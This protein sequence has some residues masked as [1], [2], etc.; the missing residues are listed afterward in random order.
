[1]TEQLIE[2]LLDDMRVAY[3]ESADDRKRL[4]ELVRRSGEQIGD[5]VGE[6][7]VNATAHHDRRAKS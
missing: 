1:M 6:A 5:P 7:A 3:R 4:D 2:Q